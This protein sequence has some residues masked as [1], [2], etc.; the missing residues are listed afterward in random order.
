MDFSEQLLFRCL[1]SGN[2]GIGKT[3]FL[4]YFLMRLI[5]ENRK[6]PN[7]NLL[8]T[9]GAGE[10]ERRYFYVYASIAGWYAVEPQIWHALKSRQKMDPNAWIVA[11]SY[12]IDGT[13][14]NAL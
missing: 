10:N 11:D 12:D 8:F 1:L 14:T 13:M 2:P 5:F 3:M 7:F 6:N 4:I 9:T